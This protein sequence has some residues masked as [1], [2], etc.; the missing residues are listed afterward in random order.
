MARKPPNR[1]AFLFL[2]K[3]MMVFFKMRMMDMTGAPMQHGRFTRPSQSCTTNP[4]TY[5]NPGRKQ[6][7]LFSAFF[8]VHPTLLKPQST[9]LKGGAMLWAK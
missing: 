9:T 1:A 3:R 8:I 6:N 2:V 4:T 7:N 5:I